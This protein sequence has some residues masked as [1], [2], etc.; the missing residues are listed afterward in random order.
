LNFRGL[1]GGLRLCPAKS[2]FL[3]AEAGVG[4]DLFEC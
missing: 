4:E 3:T 2:R 1:F